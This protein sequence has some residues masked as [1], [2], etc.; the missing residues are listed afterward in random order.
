MVIRS[1]QVGEDNNDNSS[2][3]IAAAELL[4]IIC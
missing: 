4:M 3:Q 2:V 1:R